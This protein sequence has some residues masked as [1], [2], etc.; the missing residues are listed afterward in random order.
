MQSKNYKNWIAILDLKTCLSCR[1]M[2]GQVYVMD[3]VVLVQPPLHRKYRCEIE[4][5]EA[6]LAG[7]CTSLGKKGADWSLMHNGKLPPYYITEADAKGLGYISYLG[8]LATV[9]P[10]QMITKGIYSN[11]N[12]HLP[13]APNRIWYEADINYVSGYR[14]ADRVLF[15]NDGLIFVTYDHY[16]TFVEVV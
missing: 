14:G 11:R 6:R 13:D 10:G 8:N 7:A 16:K 9:A 12:G 1:R 15:S 5:M 3:E 4:V 2:H